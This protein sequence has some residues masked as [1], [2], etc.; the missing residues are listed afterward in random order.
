MTDWEIRSHGERHHMI[1]GQLLDRETAGGTR[2]LWQDPDVGWLHIL[3]DQ[4]QLHHR[5]TDDPDRPSS[6]CTPVKAPCTPVRPPV[7]RLRV[8][9]A[10]HHALPT[11]KR[12]HVRRGLVCGVPDSHEPRGPGFLAPVHARPCTDR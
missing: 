9:P 10:K 6:P 2:V 12:V 7:G 8:P 5:A 4:T 1:A 11:R 3:K